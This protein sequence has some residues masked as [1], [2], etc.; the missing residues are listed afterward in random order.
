MQTMQLAPAASNAPVY[1]T[2]KQFSEKH[3]AFSVGSLRA[4]I[5]NAS[6][7]GLSEAGAIVRIGRKVLLNDTKFYDWIEAQRGLKAVR[8]THLLNLY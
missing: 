6:T 3:P 8:K 2:V 5:F 4:I 1:S 7:N